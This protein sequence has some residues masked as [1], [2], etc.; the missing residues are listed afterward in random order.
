MCHWQHHSLG[1]NAL[2]AYTEPEASTVIGPM[3]GLDMVI[4]QYPLE[5]DH[6]NCYVEPLL[7]DAG[8]Q[9]FFNAHSHIWNHFCSEDGMYSL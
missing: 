4:Y 6:I 7:K 2:L 3:T 5:K 9:L 1:G 8:V